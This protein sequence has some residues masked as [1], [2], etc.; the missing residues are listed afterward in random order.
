MVF[1]SKRPNKHLTLVGED[2]SNAMKEFFNLSIFSN[3][4]NVSFLSLIIKV[5]DAKHLSDFRPIRLIECQYKII[6]KILANRLSLVVDE[7]ISHE[8]SA[9]IKGR[10][11][12]HGPLILNEIVSWCKSRKEQALFS[13]WP[14][15][16]RVC[17]HSLKASVLVN[18]S[19]LTITNRALVVWQII[20]SFTYLGVKIAANMV[21]INSW[22]E[23]IQK[24]R[25]SFPN[26]K[27]N[28][29]W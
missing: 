3:G 28:L 4:W 18:G 6:G 12:L 7:L 29:Y 27:L 20:S 2:V 23:V 10:Q 22:N 8:K 19:Q 5:L 25:S 11:I 24:V 9:F 13:K 17:L 21:R 15:W 1:N 16:I 26:G 14:G